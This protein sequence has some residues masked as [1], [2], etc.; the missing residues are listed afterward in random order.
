MLDAHPRRGLVVIMVQRPTSLMLAPGTMNRSSK[1]VVVITTSGP[2]EFSFVLLCRV[3]FLLSST[4]PPSLDVPGSP[5]EHPEPQAFPFQQLCGTLTEKIY[6]FDMKP[7][8]KVHVAI[9]ACSSRIGPV[10]RARVCV[11][12]FI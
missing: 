1:F 5:L 7:K 8:L 9:F 10:S 3:V 6:P 12:V 4:R 2:L 11:C